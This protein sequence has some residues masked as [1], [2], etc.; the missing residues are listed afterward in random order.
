[1]NHK[2][3]IWF[4]DAHS[5]SYSCHYH[6][7]F[8]EQESILVVGAGGR[9]HAGMVREGSYGVHSEELGEFFHF[10]TRQA[11]NDAA[12]ARPLLDETYYIAVDISGFRA[13]FVIK[14]LAV[15]RRFKHCHIGHGK[16]F[17]YVVLH[18]RCGGCCECNQGTRADFADYRANT[19]VFRP[20]VVS[21]LRYAVGF[22][23]SVE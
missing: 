23:D 2:S 14:I 1:M 22:V 5:E 8:F 10:A 3:D 16:V 4:V 11:V 18:F 19:P 17:L 15:E 20:E 9:V 13:N 21:P 7:H 12:F 6:I